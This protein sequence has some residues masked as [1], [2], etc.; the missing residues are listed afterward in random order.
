[1]IETVDLNLL[2][3]STDINVQSFEDAMTMK[4]LVGYL[5]RRPLFWAAFIGSIFLA[6]ICV[7]AVQMMRRDHEQHVPTFRRAAKTLGIDVSDQRLLE[8]IAQSVGHENPA[9]LLISV[10]CFDSAVSRYPR[11]KTNSKAIARLRQR[12]FT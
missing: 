7:Q 10:G 6:A 2:L 4:G 5:I 1:M 9:S 12:I 8:D 11:S 3:A